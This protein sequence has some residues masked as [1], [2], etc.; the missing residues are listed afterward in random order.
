MEEIP[1]VL[2]EKRGTG[3][4]SFAGICSAWPV[5][6]KPSDSYLVLSLFVM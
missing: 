6:V 4:F 1:A 2:G 5:F 3:E